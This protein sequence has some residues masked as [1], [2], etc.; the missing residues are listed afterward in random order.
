MPETTSAPPTGWKAFAFGILSVLLS[1][2]VVLLILEAAA[3]AYLTLK[4]GK[5]V[6]ASERFEEA[7]HP[8]YHG[9]ILRDPDVARCQHIDTLFPHPYLGWV[10]HGNPPCGYPASINNIGLFRHDFPADRIKDKF[11]VM[12]TGGSVAEFV[13]GGN[14]QFV[15]GGYHPPYLERALNARWESPTGKPF[16]VLQASAG[17]WKQ[18]QAAIM[19]MLYADLV[20]G[21]VTLDGANELQR[22]H[23]WEG[24]RF[25]YPY[26]H[27]AEVNPLATDDFGGVVARWMMSRVLLWL[28]TTPPFS[29]SS[30]A[31]IIA[32]RLG[33][34]T[35]PP[36][37]VQHKQHTTVESIFAAPKSWTRQH[38]WSVALEQYAK[39][40]EE[41]HVIARRFGVDEAHFIQPLP[42]VDKTLTDEERAAVGPLDYKSDW[43]KMKASLLDLRSQGIPVFDL[44]AVFQNEKESVYADGA[45]SLWNDWCNESKGYVLISEQM[46]DVLAETWHL[47]RR[48]H[49]IEEKDCFYRQAIADRAGWVPLAFHA[50]GLHGM[51]VVESQAGAAV[52][53][54]DAPRSEAAELDP[55]FKPDMKTGMI[56]IAVRSATAGAT[57]GVLSPDRSRFLDIVQ[58]N[59]SDKPQQ[60]AL[61]VDPGLTGPI[62]IGSAD[63][64]LGGEIDISSVSYVRP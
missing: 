30:L 1:V 55:S 33:H 37:D 16:L 11:V 54:P 2:V 63:S 8:W 59:A 42:A 56:V 36:T 19:F 48:A 4:D 29:D 45:H 10:Y 15:G 26:L 60:A 7:S 64:K 21:V 14:Q 43:L 23:V 3:T 5:F 20:D 46:A 34:F 47:K 6:A 13:G 17:G 32:D 39:Y 24:F 18:P 27:F 40:I 28:Q 35:E 9:T 49:P 31:F 38:A 50:T 44:G 41:M 51:T 58:V 57:I 61:H 25:E 52:H 62:V 53:L 22:A 12:L